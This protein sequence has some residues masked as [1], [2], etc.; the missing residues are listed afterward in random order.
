MVDH[1]GLHESQSFAPE[2][3]GASMGE[4][5]EMMRTRKHLCR[6][7]NEGRKVTIC[8]V[9]HSRWGNG[10]LAVVVQGV[11]FYLRANTG[12]EKRLFSPEIGACFPARQANG[13]D[14]VCC[15]SAWGTPTLSFVG[16]GCCMSMAARTVLLLVLL[17]FGTIPAV[18]PIFPSCKS[19]R[20]VCSLWGPLRVV[21]ARAATR[22]PPKTPPC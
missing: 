1:F 14:A 9:G 18:I 17:S 4:S 22:L 21:P 3:A 11:W 19:R 2:S 5:G 12:L 20:R 8:T 13:G 7:Q 15:S 10:V 6:L 16:L